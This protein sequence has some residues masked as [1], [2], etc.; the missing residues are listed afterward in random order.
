MAFVEGPDQCRV[1]V[2]GSVDGGLRCDFGQGLPPQAWEYIINRSRSVKWNF[3]WMCESLDG[4]EVTY[5]SNRHFDIL[6]ENIVF[7]TKSATTTSG[8]RSVYKDRRD[9]YGQGLVLLNTTSHDE[10]RT[11]A[12]CM[13]QT[14]RF[15][16][17]DDPGVTEH[18]CG[19]GV[20]S[21]SNQGTWPD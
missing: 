3:V 4:G 18:F 12:G 17:P 2:D 14:A 20:C 8:L 19:E 10:P 9:W 7:V 1:W 11:W 15:L 13:A 6:N 5:R 21:E 16:D